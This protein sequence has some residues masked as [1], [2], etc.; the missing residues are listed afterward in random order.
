MR[1]SVFFLINKKQSPYNVFP[2]FLD[3]IV[4]WESDVM[5]NDDV[6]VFNDIAV[7]MNHRSKKR[8]V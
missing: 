3:V 8:G 6:E 2:L 4:R 1:F 7:S 5:D